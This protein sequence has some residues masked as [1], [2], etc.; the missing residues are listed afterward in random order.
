MTEQEARNRLRAAIEAAGG[1]LK[2]AET[3]GFTT[4]YV[5][6]V[7]HGTRE[8]ADRIMAIIGLERIGTQQIEYWEK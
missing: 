4:A 8:L 1:P 6:N 7:V 5:N 3:Y 2:F